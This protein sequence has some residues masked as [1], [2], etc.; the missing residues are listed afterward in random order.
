MREHTQAKQ[1][2]RLS[3]LNPAGA[4]CPMSNDSKQTSEATTT[5][6]ETETETPE[7]SSQVESGGEK[8]SEDKTAQAL[9]MNKK[10]VVSIQTN[11]DKQNENHLSMHFM[12]F[13]MRLY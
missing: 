10:V 13:I 11:E 9:N 12:W 2:S 8:V 1:L 5:V 3:N 6:N 4:K 7:P